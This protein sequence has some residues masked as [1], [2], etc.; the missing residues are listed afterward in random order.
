MKDF[1]IF[2]YDEYLF[3]LRAS[4]TDGALDVAREKIKAKIDAFNDPHIEAAKNDP[5]YIFP[6]PPYKIPNRAE[7]IEMPG[8]G[9]E[10]LPWQQ[11][12]KKQQV[13]AAQNELAAVIA[14]KEA[15]MA[16]APPPPPA[17]VVV[18]PPPAPAPVVAAPAPVPAPIPAPVPAPVAEK[19]PVAEA[20]KAAVVIGGDEKSEI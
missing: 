20:P 12:L 18:A 17:P 15:E 1:A 14:Q 4:T 11:Q 16:K 5:K 19:P 10:M 7:V 3:K 8:I 13:V 2:H 9:A 6:K